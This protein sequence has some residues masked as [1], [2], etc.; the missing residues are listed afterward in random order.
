[1]TDERKLEIMNNILY[2]YRD[3]LTSELITENDKFDYHLGFFIRKQYGKEIYK[4]IQE[5]DKEIF[6]KALGKK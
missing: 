2:I 4:N 1:M 6:K 5:K 3:C